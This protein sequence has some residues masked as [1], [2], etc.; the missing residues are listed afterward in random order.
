MTND[1]LLYIV[2]ARFL[3]STIS[4]F[5]SKTTHYSIIITLVEGNF[6]IFHCSLLPDNNIT[7]VAQCETNQAAVL[8]F[9][10]AKNWFLAPKLLMYSS[11][12]SGKGF[13]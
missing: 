7:C 10:A 4:C 9:P 8:F 5:Y 11:R 6:I 12:F 1:K 13:I 3:L 2:L